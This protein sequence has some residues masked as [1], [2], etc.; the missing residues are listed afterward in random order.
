MHRDVKPGNIMIEYAAAQGRPVLVDF[1]LALREE[2]EVVMTVEGQILGTFAYMSPEQAAGRSHHVDGRSDVYSLG[3]VLYQLLCGEV[4]FRGARSMILRQ[5]LNDEPRPPRRLNDKI[6]RD[7]ETVCLK[8]LA[9]QPS[10]RYATAG[11]FAAD[12][13]RFLSGE[14]VRARPIGRVSRLWRWARRNPMLASTAGLAAAALVALGVLSVLLIVQQARG[15]R[16]SQRF[17]AGLALDRGLAE[18][19]QGNVGRGMLWLARALE[20]APD[21]EAGLRDL[22]RAN[23]AAWRPWLGSARLPLPHPEPVTGAAWGM[24]GATVVTSAGST[25]RAWD[26]RTGESRGEPW[27]VGEPI[28][29]LAVS[30]A[31]AQVAVGLAAGVQLWDAATGK[32]VGNLLEHPEVVHALAFAADGRVL[33]AACGE[34]DVYLW[35]L[36]QPDQPPRR[37]PHVARAEA[38][39]FRP[40][41]DI[42][43]VGTKNGVTCLWDVSAGREL[44]VKLP[45]IQEVGAVAWDTFGRSLLVKGGA[46]R[47][48]T[49]TLWNPNTGRPQVRVQASGKVLAAALS[50]DGRRLLTSSTDRTAQFWDA[51]SG[52]PDGPP[53]RD[54]PRITGAAFDRGGSQLL[55]WGDEG[56]AWLLDVPAGT[57]VKRLETPR[58]IIQVVGFAPPRGR[59]LVVGSGSTPSGGSTLRFWDVDAELGVGPVCTHP[60]LLLTADFSPDGKTLVTG[61]NDSQARVV[62]VATGKLRPGTLAHEWSVFAAAF[63]PDGR[64][65]AAGSK[66]SAHVWDAATGKEEAVLAHPKPVVAL[67]FDPAGR[68]L[69]TGC[70]DARARLWDLGEFKSVRDFRHGGPLTAAAFDP[71]GTTIL[72]ASTDRTARLWDVAT[73]APRGAPLAHQ[74]RVDAAVFSPD[75]RRAATASADRT[76]R[77]W[78]TAMG[79]PVGPPLSHQDA[80]RAVAFHPTRGLLLTASAD[81]TVR[82]WDPVSGKPVGPA[83]P[84]DGSVK[85]LAVHPDGRLF[86]TGA[87]DNVARVWALPGPLDGAAKGLRVWVESLTALELDE[88]GSFRRLDVGAWRR[89]Q[90]LAGQINPTPAS[91][92]GAAGSPP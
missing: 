75:G 88:H 78:D 4:P 23:L 44:P 84:H 74:D 59:W 67:A 60:G 25:V 91:P 42:L 31:N 30:P 83:L 2:A 33:A 73:G 21:D 12:L 55:V 15:L 65:L 38:L 72:T 8:A 22:A 1:G 14:P 69:L 52:K 90:R 63:R 13:R 61:A 35:R 10:W 89:R 34:H 20:T 70:S 85:V 3:V 79:E 9:K 18:C 43:A 66:E 77:A 16:E 24:A 41:A 58:E 49:V 48:R 57:L 46:G 39:A 28:R 40:N 45:N 6:P 29:A 56:I 76:A 7:L 36:D 27:D 5:V 37:L 71:R 50:P 81:R 51:L 87:D 82:I 53:I 80:V 54:W 17:A 26:A 68:Y 11:E 92:A 62:D 64:Q 47:D 32:P 19:D 86:V